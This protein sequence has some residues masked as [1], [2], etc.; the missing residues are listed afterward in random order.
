[1]KF[2]Q[3]CY[4]SRCKNGVVLVDILKSQYVKITDEREIEHFK[5]LYNGDVKLSENDEMVKF[6]YEKN[7]I[8]DSNIDE[9][10]IAKSKINHLIDK[11][12]RHLDLMLYVTD[13]CNFRCIYCPEEHID[14]KFSDENWNALYKY[15]ENSI[16]EDKYDSVCISFFGGEPLL[17]TDKI[18]SFL[19]RLEAL[20]KTYP[21]VKFSHNITTNGYLLTP[22]TYDK[23]VNLKLLDYQ[24]TLDGF[25]KTHNV[26]R[27]LAGG[28]PT[29]D[30]IVENLRYIDS[31]EDNAII[32]LRTNYNES[33]IGTLDEF[34]KWQTTNFKNKK[35]RLCYFPVNKFSDNVPD[36]YLS[37][38][39]SEGSLHVEEHLNNGID[40]FQLGNG[41]CKSTLPE[42]YIISSDGRLFICENIPGNN[43]DSDVIG[44]LKKD[45][46]FKFKENF[47]KLYDNFEYEKCKKCMIYPICAGRSC[48][49]KKAAS[50]DIR[51]DCESAL[52][53][54]SK[55]ILHFLENME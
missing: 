2:G 42:H 45:G 25:A 47:D 10:E 1:M 17:E 39:F 16:K 27:P 32:H 18:I 26:T 9:Y 43:K 49:A 36:E 50:K 41:I 21:I 15:I 55:K 11:C 44:Y 8:I 33:N 13:Q 30:K 14:K 4:A 34:K 40:V 6:L 51:I 20:S 54:Y 38:M 24:I 35:I 7:Y 23:L 31:K 52:E 19:S 53:N 5:K 48:P 12:K 22:E 37:K 28:Q 46:T 29:W 3:Y